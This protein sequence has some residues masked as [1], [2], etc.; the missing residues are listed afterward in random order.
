MAF[1][2]S[3]MHLSLLSF[4]TLILLVPARLNLY[5]PDRSA[6]L[7]VQKGLGISAQLNAL[8]NPCNSV[9]ISCERRLTNNSYV[10]RVT[11]VV[12]KSYG[13]KG[14]LSP[15]IGR[16]SELKE[17]SLQNNELYDRIPVQIVDCRKLEILNLQDNQFSGKVPSKLSSLV[18]LRDL[19][20]GSNELSGNLNF[21]KYFPNL[22]KLSLADNMFTGKMPQSLKSFRNL[23]LLNI[24]GNSFLEGPVPVVSQVEHLSAD[25]NRKDYVPKRYILAENA[26]RPSRGP[27][28]APQS[29][30]GYA[31]APGP[32]TVVVPVGHKHNKIKRKVGAW[33]LGFFAGAFAGCLSALVFGML[34][35][36]LMFFIRGS[37]NDT[38]LTIFSP[39]IKK[40]EDLAFLE[41][42]DGLASLELIGQGGCGEVYK[43]ELPGSNGKTIAVKKI[44]QPPKDAAELTE[45]DSKA[46]NK[47]MLQIRSEIKIVGQ[48]RHRNLLPLLAH[49]P[50]PDCH[51]LVYEYMKNG[52]L[53]DI[54]QQ[55]REGTR[56][57]DWSARHRI[58]I[59]IAA[60]L[61]YLHIN[62]TQRIIHRDLKPGNVL[63]DDDMEARIADFGL[64]KAVPDAHTHIT[65]SNVAG[66]IGYIA[67][68]YHQTLKF[69]D[70][71][72][73]Y[74]FGVLL[75]AL[76]M[77]KLPS[78]EFFQ[79]TSEV[80]LVKWMRNVMSS[81]DP[82]R[83]IDPK[84]MGNGNEEQM[85]LVLKIACF[86]TL[87]NPK[88][89]PNSKDVRC[90]LTQIKH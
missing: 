72:D 87:E 22:E 49:M 33:I 59:G 35:K 54:L 7:L 60:G 43:A 29:Y 17:L 21:L 48:I 46:M 80:S 31:Q 82:N 67:P 3:H 8:D 53:Q 10:L 78:D 19:D 39:L 56:E 11:R 32:T 23:R 4:F 2:A 71:C 83:A 75:G 14:T 27:A 51:Y 62:H 58:A 42:E 90:M 61:E 30:S 69:T 52:S 34:F 85:L 77:G 16:L 13:L 15:A 66:T 26:R 81:E 6:L 36:L 18:R 84:L 76:V 45:E 44:I 38:G 65:T 47:K 57:L 64:A 5:S 63:L 9:G 50:R 25:L 86:C 1:T 24:S 37:I 20:L 89:R 88:E 40:A 79:N 74:S 28:M 68:E 70:K 55:V 12:F 41:K 73:V